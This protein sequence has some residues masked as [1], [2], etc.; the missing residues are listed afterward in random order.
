MTRRMLPAGLAVLLMAAPIAG[1]APVADVIEVLSIGAVDGPPEST[2]SGV[3]GVEVAST[4]DI[5]I[6][7]RGG[8]SIRVFSPAGAFVRAFGREG[9]G[10]SEFRALATIGML[11]DTVYALDWRLRKVAEFALD[12]TLIRTRRIDYS[13]WRHG[14]IS[15]IQPLR[16]GDLVLESG[17]GCNLP[18][19]PGFDSQWW[20]LLLPEDGEAITPIAQEDLGRSVPVYGTDDDPFCTAVA[21]PFRAG[22]V[23]AVRPDGVVA[24]GTGDA[25]RLSFFRLPRRGDDITGLGPP[26][27]HVSL[28]GGRRAIGRGERARWIDR[29]AAPWAGD[30]SLPGRAALVREALE[31]VRF[32]KEWPAYDRV[33]FDADGGVWVRRPPERDAGPAVWDVYAPDGEYRGRVALP[34]S[35]RVRHIRRDAVYGVIRDDWDVEYVKKY[36]V[37][38]SG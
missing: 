6:G 35:L 37:R 13:P 21:F 11:G 33:R 8:S 18:R 3:V 4:G 17:S 7:D 24:Y 10:P 30:N 15:R 19:R 9:D 27:G 31:A 1:Q 23:A 32:P 5:L 20:L 25:G 2:L 16:S 12:G 34:A 14:L 28:P 38:W 36:E 22:P 26:I 29:Q